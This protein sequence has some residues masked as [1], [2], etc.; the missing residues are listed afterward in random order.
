MNDL[1]TITGFYKTY[2]ELLPQYETQKECFDFLNAEVKKINGEKMFFN[3][4]DFQIR[5]VGKGLE[6]IPDFCKTYFNLLPYFP[7]AKKCFEYLHGISETRAENA[8]FLDYRD[9]KERTWR[10]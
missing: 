6:T 2:L 1:T 3:L 7:S 4:C 5:T 9:F 10:V 8:L